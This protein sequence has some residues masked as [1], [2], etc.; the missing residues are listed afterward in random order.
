MWQTDEVSQFLL[1][2]KRKNTEKSATI[3]KICGKNKEI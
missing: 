3:N 1:K 2:L